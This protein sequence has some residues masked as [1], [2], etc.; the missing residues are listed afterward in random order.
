MTLREE[1]IQLDLMVEGRREAFC[2]VAPDALQRAARR[3]Y[4]EF[5][6]SSGER[7]MA[8]EDAEIR[9]ACWAPL[10]ARLVALVTE[11]GRGGDPAFA[12]LALSFLATAA[13]DRPEAGERLTV[14][15]GSDGAVGVER[16]PRRLL[17][18]NRVALG[19]YRQA[20]NRVVP[21]MARER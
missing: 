10:A 8:M 14:S 17:G 18:R 11:G 19:N 9:E 5:R 16:R 2:R 15:V 3:L 1:P 21:A 6:A 4:D 12:E 20:M 13:F 7:G